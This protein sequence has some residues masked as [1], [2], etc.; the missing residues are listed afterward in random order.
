MEKI[1]PFV[2]I[3]NECYRELEYS[4]NKYKLC[5]QW[6]RYFYDDSSSMGG[7][8]FIW[9]KLDG[10]LASHRGQA[11]IPNIKIINELVAQAV[12]DGWGNYTE[13][14]FV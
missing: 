4:G 12:K 10:T 3:I 7:Y 8:R 13:S 6:C 2:Q 1:K 5:F 9:R 11:R 14:V